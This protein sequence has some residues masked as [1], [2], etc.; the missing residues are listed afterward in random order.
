VPCRANIAA[1]KSLGVRAILVFSAVGSLRE[2]IEPGSFVI[3]LQIIDQT[4][5][6]RP[7]SFFEDTQIIA[8]TSFGDQGGPNLEI[9]DTILGGGGGTGLLTVNVV[10]AKYGNCGLC[11]Q[12]FVAPMHFVAVV[13]CLEMLKL[14]YLLFPPFAC[15]LLQF[16]CNTTMAKKKKVSISTQ[17]SIVTTRCVLPVIYLCLT[18]SP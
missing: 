10:T 2:E 13:G 4:K 9:P 17:S 12:Y 15:I 8:H 7:S 16:I 11:G 5:G 6:I 3:L 18:S 14:N 1:L